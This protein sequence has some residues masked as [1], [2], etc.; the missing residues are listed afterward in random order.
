MRDS[1]DVLPLGVRVTIIFLR[2]FCF[3]MFLPILVAGLAAMAGL[4]SGSFDGDLISG[5]F[6]FATGALGVFL[7]M[8]MMALGCDWL[9]RHL[10]ATTAGEWN[11]RIQCPVH[12][13]RQIFL[14]P[15]GC[16][17]AYAFLCV[18]VWLSSIVQTPLAET[19]PWPAVWSALGF[20]AM[21][22]FHL[23]DTKLP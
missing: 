11:T 19:W 18:L 8:M 1:G 2:M 7:A 20:G 15:L 17:M 16:L 13:A 10:K 9:A 22:L 14:P 21:Y 3:A 6:L 5:G 4:V 23:L 12:P